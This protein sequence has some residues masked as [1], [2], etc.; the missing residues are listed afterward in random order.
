MSRLQDGRPGFDSQQGQE[1][2]FATISRPALRPTQ[3]PMKLVVGALSLGIKWSGHGAH[4]SPPS[5]AKVKNA[6]SCVSS[7]NA[8][9]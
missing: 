3:P 4:H 7:P 2:S 9:L 8:S 1:S 6:Q 5:S